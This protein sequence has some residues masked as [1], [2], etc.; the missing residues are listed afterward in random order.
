YSVGEAV[1]L[2]AVYVPDENG[3]CVLDAGFDPASE[4]YQLV[5][6]DPARF[7]EATVSSREADGGLGQR[8]ATTADGAFK[9]IGSYNIARDERCTGNASGD[10]ILCLRNHIPYGTGHSGAP[11]CDA[12]DVASTPTDAACGEPQAVIKITQ[13]E[14]ACDP[15]TRTVHAVGDE[16]DPGD[17]YSDETGT[18]E[19]VSLT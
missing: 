17:V 5:Q 1:A 10:D 12:A 11:S 15:P 3:G 2:T 16:L 8:V 9:V 7:A 19:A 14:D 4:V 18:C 6:A 13:G